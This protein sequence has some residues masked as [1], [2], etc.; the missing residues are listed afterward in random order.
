MFVFICLS[1]QLL[2]LLKHPLDILFIQY[3]IARHFLNFC[4]IIV[5][6]KQFSYFQDS[7]KVRIS[8]NCCF[9]WYYFTKILLIFMLDII[10]NNFIR[11]YINIDNICLCLHRSVYIHHSVYFQC[12]LFFIFFLRMFSF[13]GFI[14]F[15]LP[16]NENRSHGNCKTTHIF[17]CKRNCALLLKY[18]EI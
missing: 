10:T 17:T 18:L 15:Y 14:T 6:N 4:F 3:W 11:Y 5:M 7:R 16:L 2:Y 8:T 12:S 13:I 1:R 9:P